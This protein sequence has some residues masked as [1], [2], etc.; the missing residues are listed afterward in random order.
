MPDSQGRASCAR[1]RRGWWL[2]ASVPLLAL[3][4]ACGSD[5]DAPADDAAVAAVGGGVTTA[6]PTA[7]AEA[8]DTAAPS[9]DDLAVAAWGAR[10]C[11]IADDFALDFLAS[12]DP[13]NPVE[14]GVDSR[15]ERA[16]AMFP[17]QLDAVAE[18]IAR[19]DEVEAPER[20]AQLHGLLRQ[21]YQDLAAALEEQRAVIRVST[22]AEEISASNT[23]VNQLID[24]AF[25]QS[26]LLQNAGYC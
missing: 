11:R 15:K 26:A 19:L 6:T 13:R 22:T 2:I 1:S 20:T 24:L 16:E 21:T 12:G 10:V 17:L 4:V 8:T 18:A 7:A 9:V 14:L 23:A 3:L 25:R 5:D